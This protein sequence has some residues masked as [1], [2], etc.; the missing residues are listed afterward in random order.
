MRKRISEIL[1]GI[2]DGIFPSIRNSIKKDAEGHT[3]INRARLTAAVLSWMI[4]IALLKGWI[5]VSQLASLITSIFS[6]NV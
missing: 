4:L 5:T 2:A 6:L 1:N 3:E